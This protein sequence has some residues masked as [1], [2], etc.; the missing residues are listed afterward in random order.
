MP[1]YLCFGCHR[2]NPISSLAALF[3]LQPHQ[4]FQV[5][6][7][8]KTSSGI[9][10]L[11]IISKKLTVAIKSF[12]FDS[13]NTCLKAQDKLIGQSLHLQQEGRSQR[14]WRRTAA[15]ISTTET[16]GDRLRRLY[17]H[18]HHFQ[19]HQEG[20][21]TFP[22]SHEVINPRSKRIRINYTELNELKREVLLRLFVDVGFMFYFLDMKGSDCTSFLS[23]LTY[24]NLLNSALIKMKYF[25]RICALHWYPRVQKLLLSLLNFHSSRFNR[26]FPPF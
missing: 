21:S 11:K 24:N 15:D 12:L 10:R 7:L 22:N 1:F 4:T 25:Q 26:T 2:N 20:E 8:Y 14:L 6:K 23:Y 9:S 5:R 16:Y 19:P 3:L 13:E 18:L 17:Q